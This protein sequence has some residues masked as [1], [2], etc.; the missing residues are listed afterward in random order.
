MAA[1]IAFIV[2]L[3]LLALVPAAPAS[4][5]VTYKA[6][7]A[8]MINGVTRAQLEPTVR[9][10]SGE[11]AAVVGGS[12]Y[13][14]TTRS[15]SS[16]TSIDMAEQY[17]YEHLSSYGLDSVA[18]QD[19]PG[20]GAVPA[21][22]NVIGQINGTTTPSEIIVIGAHLDDVPWSGSAPGADDNASG[23]SALLYLART[24]AGY[25]FARTIRFIAFGDEENVPWSKCL[26]GSGYYACN[27]ASENIVAM[28][29]VDSIAYNTGQIAEMHTRKPADDPGGSEAAMATMW[30]DVI[31]AYSIT[32]LTPFK[33]DS[34]MGLSDHDAFW[35]WI[36]AAPAIMLIEDDTVGNPYWHSVNDRV[37]AFNWPFYVATT[38]SLVGLAAH[39]AGIIGKKAA[40][41]WDPSV[42]S[43]RVLNRSL[44]CNTADPNCLD[45][46]RAWT[47]GASAVAASA[48][49][50]THYIHAVWT[51]D[52]PTGD[53]SNAVV[54]HLTSTCAGSSYCSGVYYARSTNTGEIYADPGAWDGGAA[55]TAPFAVSPTNVHSGRA[56][57]TTSGAYVHVAYVV[58]TNYGDAMCAEANRVLWVRTN[59]NYGASGSWNAP[60][61]ISGTLKEV[62]YPSITASGSTVNVI[63]TRS[64]DGAVRAARSTDNGLNYT[65]QTLDTTAA[66]YDNKV[67]PG[68]PTCSG[69][70]TPSGLEGYSGRATIASSG[71]LVGASWISNASGRAIAEISTDGGATFYNGSCTGGSGLCKMHLAPEGA[72]GPDGRS[73]ISATAASGRVAFA[74][75]YDTGLSSPKGLYV[76]TYLSAG[77][78]GP[79]RLM[80]CMQTAGVC[81][82]APAAALYSDGYSPSVALFGTTGI[83]VVWSACPYPGPTTPC[84][85]TSGDPGA[86]LLYKESFDGGAT[87]WGGDS[88]TGIWGSYRQI[89]A[90]TGTSS[91]V[92]ERP[93]LIFDDRSVS[94]S[95]GCAQSAT[96]TPAGLPVTGCRRYVLYV[97]HTKYTTGGWFVS[98]AATTRLYTSVGTQL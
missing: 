84:D 66:T 51:T 11:Q 7:V 70:P 92:N 14:I 6:D 87:W 24:M 96:S 40:A 79:K 73:L 45:S 83:G 12:R 55:S 50:A 9:D 23:V 81:S 68:S 72:L 89:V 25:Q 27:A 42:G 30:Q 56:A 32:G 13:T 1:A 85:Q 18:Y 90:D 91:A 36:P 17:V 71:T 88:P 58:T 21:G 52:A 4:A 97:G 63:W 94:S 34:G 10:L 29:N 57:I 41:R 93:S 98:N 60:V 22:R 64:Y 47:T 54:S 38:K 46:G 59:T 48:N 44:T 16:V 39:Q 77:G 78:W 80:S 65:S 26:A 35:N 37:S 62:D 33:H 28:I 19:F 8:N 69:A 76:R 5:A 95:V 49:G 82:T 61:Q 2:L 67:S 53:E 75:V 86:D 43:G 3:A 74:W 20:K 15:S 31:T